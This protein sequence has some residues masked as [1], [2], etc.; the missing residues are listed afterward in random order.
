MNPPVFK[1]DLTMLI[2]AVAATAGTGTHFTLGADGEMDAVTNEDYVGALV[3][4]VPDVGWFTTAAT[5]QWC[6]L[7]SIVNRSHIGIV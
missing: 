6:C 5:L 2:P 1:I 7:D 4:L 3:Q